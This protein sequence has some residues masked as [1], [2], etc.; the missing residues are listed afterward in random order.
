MLSLIYTTCSDFY[1]YAAEELSAQWG[2][3]NLPFSHQPVFDAPG[4]EMH[5]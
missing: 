5:N 4:S 2:V 3:L 1:R